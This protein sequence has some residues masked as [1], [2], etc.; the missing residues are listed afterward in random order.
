MSFFV[1]AIL[2]FRSLADRRSP[3]FFERLSFLEVSSVFF[4]I[5][6][7]LFIGS[8]YRFLALLA[9]FLVILC[10]VA[11][12]EIGKYIGK[13]E[14]FYFILLI[15]TLYEMYFA[16]DG[17]FL[18]FPDFGVVK[19][20]NYLEQSF[21]GTRSLNPPESPNPHLQKIIN[22]SLS[23]RQASEAPFL[24]VY[25]EN[26]GLSARLWVFTRRIYHHGIRVVTTGQFRGLLRNN[27]PE[28][29]SGYKIYFIKTYPYTSLNTQ[30]SIPD[31]AEFESFLTSQLNLAPV[32]RI[33]GY[34][35]LPMFDVYEFTM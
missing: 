2:I 19:L 24:V 27:G 30:L 16:I 25:D 15:F 23:R 8:A 35:N 3:S 34:Q 20:D 32:K 31:A 18:T 26:I 10:V 5:A 12:I 22:E 14:T 6:M 1:F 33:T 9:P 21:G 13:K 4:I 11:L 29:F 28:S 7:L 17:V